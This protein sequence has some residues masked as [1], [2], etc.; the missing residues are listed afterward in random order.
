MTVFDA[1]IPLSLWT[2]TALLITSGVALVGHRTVAAWTGWRP[3]AALGI[4]LILGATVAITLTPGHASTHADLRSCVPHD[5]RT[6]AEA[7]HLLGHD[8]ENL[9]NWVLFVPF[10]VVLQ[11]TV[12]GARFT[13]PVIVLLPAMIE[14][15]QVVV[16]GRLC[17]ASDYAANIAGG[18]IAVFITAAIHRWRTSREPR[19]C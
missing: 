10:A 19:P 6:L 3:R 15:V 9:L 5:R 12:R 16:P 11:W 8:M 4:L 17:A 1:E 13:V 2:V 14:S 18:L 7:G